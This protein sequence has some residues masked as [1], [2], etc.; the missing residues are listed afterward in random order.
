MA[1]I[2]MS[3][4]AQQPAQGR[5]LASGFYRSLANG[6]RR[7]TARIDSRAHDDPSEPLYA[8]IAELRAKVNKLQ[9]ERAALLELITEQQVT[10][11][12]LRNGSSAQ[13]LSGSTIAKRFF[14]H[15]QK[16]PLALQNG[17]LQMQDDGIP[18]ID[19]AEFAKAIIPF[20]TSLATKPGTDIAIQPSEHEYTSSSGGADDAGLA[21][22]SDVAVRGLYESEMHIATSIWIVSIKNSQG[23]FFDGLMQ[24][25]AQKT[26]AP[27]T[28][29][30]A[31]VCSLARIFSALCLLAADI[32]RVRVMLCDLLMD[33]VD[34]PHTL[35][36][37]SNVLAVCPEALRMPQEDEPSFNSSKD[38]SAFRLVVR[39]FQAIASGIHDLYSEEHSK[40]EADALYTIM[41]ERC[42]WRHPSDAEY[43]DKV[44]VEAGNT[45][46]GL[47]QTSSNYSVVMCAYSLLAPYVLT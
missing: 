47:E 30:V 35:P 24:L 38:L 7:N 44:F 4:H 36:V 14:S 10:I 9:Q 16:A 46:A 26:V 17:L 40:A 1:A 5:S 18:S 8:E 6:K 34:S 21:Q 23:R 37:L 25:L 19:A 33:A 43:A 31:A 11:R 15:L 32:Q 12:H 42:G 28:R 29:S 2:D 3:T 41:V 13:R 27:A 39:V 22:L 20:V 45:L